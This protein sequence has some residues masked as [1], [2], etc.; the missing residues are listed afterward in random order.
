[1]K[2]IIG[3]KRY[4]TATAQKVASDSASCSKSDFSYYAES[5]YRTMSGRFYLVGE[6]GPMSHYAEA[7][8]SNSWTGGSDLRPLSEKEAREWLEQTGNTEALEDHFAQ[9]IVDA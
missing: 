6:G 9:S 2:K 5:L 3:G 1:M 4:D 7:I 8:D